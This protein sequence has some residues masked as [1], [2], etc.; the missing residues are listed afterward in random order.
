MATLTITP[1]PI[2]WVDDVN[3]NIGT[4]NLDTGSVSL[5][6]SSGQQLTDIAL[7]STGQLFGESFTTLYSIN[8]S[9]AA[10][11]IGPTGAVLNGLVFNSNGTLYASGGTGLYTLNTTTGAATLIGN[12]GLGLKS[13]G[14]LSFNNGNLYQT[15]TDGTNTDLLKVDPLTG[16][17]TVVGQVVADPTMYGLATGSDGVLYGFDGNDIYSINTTTGAGTLVQTFGGGLGAAWGAASQADSLPLCFLRGTRIATPSGEVPIEDLSPG[18]HIL[19]HSG[20]VRPIVWIGEG[21]MLATRRQRGA[22]TP[23]IVRMDAFGDGIP[24]HDLRVTRAHAF[25]FD[26]V[27]IPAEF[28]INQ[29]SILWD[30][31]PQEVLLYHIELETHDVLIANGAPA[32]SFRDDGNRWLF[33]NAWTAHQGAQQACAPVITGGAVVDAV[34]QRLLDRANQQPI[35]PLTMDPEP[36]LLVDGRRLNPVA[37][38]R[39]VYTFQLPPRPGRVRIVSRAASPMELGLARDPRLLGIALRRVILWDGPQV[40]LL[41]ASDERLTDGFHG[42]EPDDGIRWTCGDAGLPQDVFTAR[43]ERSFQLELHLGGTTPYL[44]S[45]DMA[46]KA[47]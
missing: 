33:R 27:L 18:D 10:T 28:L 35:G 1:A 16:A 40:E 38:H 46:M 39:N 29:R 15:A 47:A 2:I 11:T 4:V 23:V 9:G 34:W 3:G 36:Y 5:L 13:A 6:G 21:R 14:D 8:Q 45:A 41:E 24:N 22:A 25:L 20:K 30:D 19:T 7:S 17:A 31:E 26:D 32:E 12:S 37:V 42:Y 43:P 44:L